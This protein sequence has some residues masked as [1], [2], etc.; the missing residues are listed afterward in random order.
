MQP[1]M[2][3]PV[4]VVGQ[5][6]FQL[7]KRVKPPVCNKFRLDHLEGRFR[8]RVIIWTTLHAQGTADLKALQEFIDQ[9]I[10]K[11]TAAICVKD[12]DIKQ[13]SFHGHKDTAEKDV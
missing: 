13:V 4:N 11:L 7:L 2:I 12:L 6:Q 8:N 9:D 3:E 10:V 1:N 5:F